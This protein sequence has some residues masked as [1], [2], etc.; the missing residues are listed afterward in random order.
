MKSKRT[1]RDDTQTREQG[2][3]FRCAR[4]ALYVRRFLFVSA[5]TFMSCFDFS[6][7]APSSSLFVSSE[8]IHLCRCKQH[9]TYT[10]PITPFFICDL[11]ERPNHNS[12]WR[13]Y[14]CCGGGTVY[15]W[16][17]WWVVTSVFVHESGPY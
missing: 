10:G 1:R 11:H 9:S 3:G 13:S 12:S 17:W 7:L 15:A 8:V 6:S 14:S 5:Q 2:P 16:W 4:F